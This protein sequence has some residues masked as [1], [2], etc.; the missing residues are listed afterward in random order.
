MQIYGY[1]GERVD[2]V[3]RSGGA[4]AVM[5]GDTQQLCVAFFGPAHRVDNAGPDASLFYFNDSIRLDFQGDRLQAVRVEPG[6]TRE[7]VA[8]YVDKQQ[9]HLLSEDEA[10]ELVGDLLAVEFGEDGALVAVTYRA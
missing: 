9:L 8:L 1:L 4:G 2:F 6:L 5:F 3:S 10:A 7:K